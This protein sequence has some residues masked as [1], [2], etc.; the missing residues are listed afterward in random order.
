MRD[1]A[2]AA[3]GA[4]SRDDAGGSNDR[5]VAPTDFE[6]LAERAITAGVASCAGSAAFGAS[7]FVLGAGG[8]GG[9][10]CAR[11]RRRGWTSRPLPPTAL[12]RSRCQRATVGRWWHDGAIHV[13]S[14]GAP[15][16]YATRGTGASQGSRVRRQLRRHGALYR[17]RPQRARRQ[18][19]I[20]PNLGHRVLPIVTRGKPET[21]DD[22]RKSKAAHGVSVVEIARQDGHLADRPGFAIQPP[23]HPRHADGDHR[24]C[25]RPRPHEDRSRPPMARPRSAPG[26][27]AATGA[28]PGAPILPAKRT[29]TAISRRAIPTSRSARPRIATA[30]S[31]RTGAMA[32]R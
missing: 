31:L 32:G 19:R 20:P 30:S 3:D 6:Q 5:H 14:E 10:A 22:V 7:A 13:W 28:R 1:Q 12:I 16:D 4:V 8:V 17:G 23:H 9:A 26:T 25:A 2:V 27:T 24:A 15:F 29:S 11:W 18:Q 21:E